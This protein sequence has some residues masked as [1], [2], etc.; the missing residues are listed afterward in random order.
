MIRIL[1][2][3]GIEAIYLNIIKIVHDKPTVNIILESEK[4]KAFLLKSETKHGCPVSPFLFNIV[5]ELLVILIGEEIKG[6]QDGNE[7][8]K[9]SLFVHD[10]MHKIL[11]IPR[12][13]IQTIT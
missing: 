7:E 8:I 3:V 13:S 4:L 2:Q 9:L 5:L 1:Q 6:V 12:K 11:K 10:T